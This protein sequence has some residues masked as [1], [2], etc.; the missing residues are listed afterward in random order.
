MENKKT[1]P[2]TLAIVAL[3]LGVIFFVSL[4]VFSSATIRNAQL[5]LTKGGL[6]T[7]SD[8]TRQ[9]L[10]AVKEPITLRYFISRTLLDGS[11]GIATYSARVLELIERYVTLSNGNIRL[12]IVN[13]EPF[14]PEEDRAVG[15]QLQGIPVSDTGELG[16]FGLAG[17]NTTDDQDVI[18]FF[19]PQREPFLEYDLTRLINNLANPKKKVIGLLGALPIDAD[20]AGQ[21][22]PWRVVQQLKQFFEV[23]SMGLT[24]EIKDDVDV[25][26]IV[27]PIGL[28]DKALY[29]IDQ[30]V[31]RGGKVMVFVDPFAEEGSRSNAAMRLPP[32][33]GSNLEKL[34]KAWGVEY[35]NDKVLGDRG[36]AQ[37]VQ[38]GVDPQGR[39]IITEYVAWITMG[40]DRL[41]TD[42]VI[43]SQLQVLN[44]ASAGA[45]SK[46]KDAKIEFEPLV[47]STTDAMLVDASKVRFQPNP[48]TI[49]ESFKSENKSY[50]LAARVSGK[51]NS[52]FPDGEPKDKKDKDAQKEKDEK[53]A[54]DEKK[55]DKKAASEHLKESKVPANIIIVADTDVLADRSWLQIQELFGQQL[56]VPTANNADFVI[57][58][59]DNLAGSSALIG[60]RG[61]GLSSRPFVRVEE[62]RK[63]AETKFRSREQE[64]VKKLEDIEKKLKDLQTKEK[65]GGDLVL[66]PDQKKAINNFRA[67][68]V[69]TRRDLR[70]VQLKLRQEIDRLDTWVKVANIGAMPL[71]VALFAIL[72]AVFRR[73]R[74]GRGRQKQAVS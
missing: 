38:A 3:A 43:S 27:H 23:R 40:R 45:I 12:E 4:N 15:F 46:A 21:Y 73:G 47:T 41:K 25:L 56:V 37:R 61:R 58:A 59:A 8:G 5:D 14:S 18:G 19:S 36:S 34:F 6:F 50:V 16:Y 28:D 32:D 2:K 35:V 64:L 74:A 31:L 69:Q 60:L 7:L 68:M 49:L 48:A 71:L 54:N 55:E 62:I 24:P 53:A 52:A 51:L 11:P 67:E 72:L 44:F 9:V 22:K 57:N 1:S 65:A 63:D 39:P 20:P 30:F 17:T 26:L 29:K 70:D 10:S 13:P 42:D 33:S 66:S